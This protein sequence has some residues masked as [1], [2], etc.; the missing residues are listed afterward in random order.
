M[1]A[2]ALWRT[3]VHE[4]A[5]GAFALHHGAVGVELTAT[6][7]GG[8]CS[9]IGLPRLA[10]FDEATFSAVGAAGSR[11]ARRHKSKPSDRQPRRRRT[12]LTLKASKF[13]KP[14]R[15]PTFGA[16]HPTP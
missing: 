6:L 14:E 8:L 12:V 11:L 7:D 4:A 9:P 13:A 1:C 10:G 3:S 16:L 2:E 15:L 5:H